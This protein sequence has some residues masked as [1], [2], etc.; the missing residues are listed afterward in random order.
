MTQS[1]TTK[2][3]DQIEGGVGAGDSTSGGGA[4][5]GK[6]DGDTLGRTGDLTTR[7]DPREDRKKLFPEQDEPEKNRSGSIENWPKEG[8]PQ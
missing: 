7:G 1:N 5:A 4:A 8:S 2:P 3:L 6:P